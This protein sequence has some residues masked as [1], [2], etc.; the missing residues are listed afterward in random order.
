MSK[1]GRRT[2]FQRLGLGLVA[3]GPL[4][5]LLP[6]AAFGESSSQ[7]DGLSFDATT[8]GTD[9]L[10][11]A[12]AAAQALLSPLRPGSRIASAS[13]DAIR[14]RDGYLS[15]ELT[16]ASGAPFRLEICARDLLPG[17]PRPVTRTARYDLFVA[18]GGQGDRRTERAHGLAAYAVADVLSA[19]E[20][21]AAVALK[22]LRARL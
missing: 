9:R 18:N 4:G 21:T 10:D 7:P 14:T 8:A 6:T 16:A 12:A 20:G 13:L 3:S 2:F 1:I 11:E 22:T 19:N 17:A 5:A 15:L